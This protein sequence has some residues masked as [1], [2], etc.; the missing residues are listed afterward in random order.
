M[1]VSPQVLL[2]LHVFRA[3]RAGRKITKNGLS[4]RLGLSPR[5]LDVLL[6]R[7]EREGHLDGTRLCLTLPGFAVAAASA[8]LLAD[9]RTVHDLVGEGVVVRDHERAA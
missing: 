9:R 6:S 4:R 1:Q 3:Q 8:R 5:T 2:L 7:L